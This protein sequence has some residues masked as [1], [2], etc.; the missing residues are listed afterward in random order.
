M[1]RMPVPEDAVA[2][3]A[4]RGFVGDDHDAATGVERGALVLR[5]TDN[6]IIAP[7]QAT[8]ALMRIDAELADLLIKLI[9]VSEFMNEKLTG[10]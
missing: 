10:N 5:A 4:D 3:V 7:D 6:V 9:D 8:A 2:W 1:I